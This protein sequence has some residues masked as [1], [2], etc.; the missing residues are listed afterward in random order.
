MSLSKS[1]ETVSSFIYNSKHKK[2]KN[3]VIMMALVMSTIT[4]GIF[5]QA[6]PQTTK[7]TDAQKEQISNVKEKYAPA[8]SDLRQEIRVISTEQ[9]GLLTSKT[10]DEKS[11]YA[12]IDKMGQLKADMQKQT[13]AMRSEMKELCPL[14]KKGQGMHQGEN[15]KKQV[16]NKR[17][18]QE[19][20][21]NSNQKTHQK[22]GQKG[23][24]MSTKGQKTY[25]AKGKEMKKGGKQNTNSTRHG[26][27]LKLSTEQTEEIAQIKKAHFWE[28]QETQN[29][30]A[31]LKVK[32]AN[33]EEQLKA[34]NQISALQTKLAK[35]KMSV[36]LETMQVMTE[37]QRIKMIS[38][39]GQGRGHGQQKGHKKSMQGQHQKR[40]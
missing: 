10:I 25:A 21:A 12:N 37:E 7:L 1:A 18:N 14:A 15:S 30:L 34:V 39:K 4:T 2:M 13:I 24:G 16:N 6:R 3:K 11:I 28:I 9:H 38:A 5:A 20:Q 23:Q 35:Q 36:K 32:S 29:E 31:L 33:S 17:Q 27:F 40:A 22:G 26:D 19:Q 8:I